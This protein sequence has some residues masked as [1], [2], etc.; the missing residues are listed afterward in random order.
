MH[1]GAT[2]NMFFLCCCNGGGGE[3]SGSGSPAFC[4]HVV[5]MVIGN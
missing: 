1:F 3:G 5:S 2:S 4:S